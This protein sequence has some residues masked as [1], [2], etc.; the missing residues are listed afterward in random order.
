MKGTTMRST[1]QRTNKCAAGGLL[2]E[3]RCHLR[4]RG[5]IAPGVPLRQPTKP[6]KTVKRRAAWAAVETLVEPI[7]T[8]AAADANA[9]P[10]IDT[11][12]VGNP[13]DDGITTSLNYISLYFGSHPISSSSTASGSTSVPEGGCGLHIGQDVTGRVFAYLTPFTSNLTTAKESALLLNAYPYP[14][15]LRKSHVGHWVKTLHSYARVTAAHGN[16]TVKDK[17]LIEYVRAHAAVL[18]EPQ[19]LP[20]ALAKLAKR[21]IFR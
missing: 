5:I 12:Y 13:A 7:F 17:V 4:S 1:G 2:Y 20:I 6:S 10:G 16:A 8:Q 15:L 21:V 3:R 19:K 18:A 11:L 14:Q 9:D